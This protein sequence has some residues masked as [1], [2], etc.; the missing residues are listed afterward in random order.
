M[1]GARRSRTSSDKSGVF[2]PGLLASCVLKVAFGLCTFLFEG[3]LARDPYDLAVKST[4]S[5]PF[6]LTP[7]VLSRTDDPVWT[8]FHVHPSRSTGYHGVPGS[9]LFKTHFHCL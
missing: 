7:V 5:Q 6:P 4:V 1:P 8:H 9:P 3:N 2:W